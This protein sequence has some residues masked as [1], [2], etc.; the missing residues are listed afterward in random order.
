M[1][2]PPIEVLHRDPDFLVVYKPSGLPTTSPD[3][4]GCLVE[5]VRSLDPRA[6]QLHPTSRLDAEVTGVVTFARTPRGVAHSLAM[7]RE[8]RYDR[9]YLAVT[10]KAPVP[11][12]G[13]WNGSI[14]I[15]PRDKRKRVVTTAHGAQ[16]AETRY[17][18]AA[19]APA[20][21]LLALHPHTGRTHQL[22]VHASHAG[23]PLLGDVHYGGPRRLTLPDG[24][25]LTFGRVMLHCTR[26]AFPLPSGERGVFVARPPGDFVAAWKGV[27]G[28]EG[29]LGADAIEGY[30]GARRDV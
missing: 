16:Q 6:P 26:V 8:G 23:S 27:G 20:A 17:C 30:A 7:R 5:R 1:T 4:K 22:R 9:M 24:R 19:H 28:E 13:H 25:V 12:F 2:E 21:V 15:D 3:G 11:E 14:G 10:A 29:A 18:V